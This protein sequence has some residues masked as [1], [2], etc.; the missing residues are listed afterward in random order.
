VRKS[1]RNINDTH[2]THDKDANMECGTVWF[3]NIDHVER[4]MKMDKLRLFKCGLGENVESQLDRT[5][6]TNEEV[7]LLETIGEE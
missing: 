4:G 3:R 7:S 2:H 5:F 1:K 6:K